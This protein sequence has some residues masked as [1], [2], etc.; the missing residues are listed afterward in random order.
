MPVTTDLLQLSKAMKTPRLVHYLLVVV[1]VAGLAFAAE[2]PKASVSLADLMTKEELKAT[3]V[4]RLSSAE[5]AALEEWL[6]CFA[7]AVAKNAE[8]ATAP[9]SKSQRYSGVGQRH[10]VK[11]RIDRGAYIKLEDGSLWQVSPLDKLN[12]MLWLPT[13]DV[14]VIEG[15]NPLY[16]YKLVGERDAAEAKLVAP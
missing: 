12:T 10:W 7:V 2:T 4:S 8:K 9:A 14:I 1:I 16:P 5:R 11:E 13:D 3:G 15:S 6:T